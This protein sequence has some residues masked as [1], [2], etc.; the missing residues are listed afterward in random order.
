MFNQI[1]PE[2]LLQPGTEKLS[3]LFEEESEF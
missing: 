3:K 1:T 2:D